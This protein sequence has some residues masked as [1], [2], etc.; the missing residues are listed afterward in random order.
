VSEAMR[1]RPDP[2]A[3]R[4]AYDTGVEHWP[5][6]QLG[7]EVFFERVTNTIRNSPHGESISIDDLKVE[8]LYLVAALEGGDNRAWEVF[9]TTYRPH[10]M[11]ALGRLIRD[12]RER[13]EM[14]EEVLASLF[15]PREGAC[16]IPLNTY[17]GK[18]GLK[19]WVQVTAVRRVYRNT[20]D[21]RRENWVRQGKEPQGPA[22]LDPGARVGNQEILDALRTAVPRALQGLEQEDRTLLRM[23]YQRGFQLKDLGKLYDLDKSTLSK[24][25]KALAGKLRQAIFEQ[26]RVDQQFETTDI[27]GVWEALG[28]ERPEDFDTWL[29][30]EN[31]E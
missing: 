14:A 6:V 19:G 21:R 16:G 4:K 15:M 26:L 23:R 12:S 3:L 28:R 7:P 2:E 20:R 31:E 1:E 25:L 13:E 5:G 10:V 24:R 27:E 22:H 29:G 18:G 30:R 11:Q 8:D 9:H 17:S